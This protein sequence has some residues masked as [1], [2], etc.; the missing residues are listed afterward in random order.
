MAKDLISIR[1]VKQFTVLKGLQFGHLRWA[2]KSS[3]TSKIPDTWPF[4]HFLDD[5]RVEGRDRSCQLSSFSQNVG[6]DKA[7]INF[8]YGLYPNGLKSCVDSHGIFTVN[9]DLSH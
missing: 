3:Q 1:H 6:G 7:H 2:T 9:H 4:Y 5:N 8:R